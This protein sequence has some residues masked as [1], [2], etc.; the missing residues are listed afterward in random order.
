MRMLYKY[1]QAE[2]PYAA[3]VEENRRR[4]PNEPEFELLDTGVFDDDRYFDVEVDYAKAA[5]DDILMHIIVDQSRPRP[6]PLHVLPQLWA[7]N[8]WSWKPGPRNRRLR[9]RAA[10]RDRARRTR[11]CRRCGWSATARPRLLF[12]ENETNAAA[13]R[14]RRPAGYFKDGIN[15]YVVAATAA[16][17]NPAR[18]GTKAAAHYLR[19]IPAR[20]RR[21]RPAAAAPVRARPAAFDD[22]DAIIERRRDEADEFYAALQN[23]IADPDARARAASGARRHA[24]DEAV[25]LFRCPRWLHGDPAQPPPPP[26]AAR[27]Q[28]R[29]AAPQQRRHHLDAGQV[30]VSRGT[31]PGTW[32]FTASRLALIDPDFAKDQLLLLTREWYMHPNGQ[33]PAYEWAFGDV[34]PPVHAWAAWRVYQ[35]DRERTRHRRP[36]LSRSAFPQ[37]DAEFHLVGEPQGRRG[38]QRVPGRVS[39]ARQ[40]R[41]FRPQRAVADRRPHQPGRRHRLDGDVFAEPDAHR[42]GTGARTTTSTRTSRPSSSSTSSTSPQAMT[43]IGGDGIGLWDEED[44]FYYDVLH[45]PDGQ[46]RAAAGALDGRADP[47]VRGRGARRIACSSTC[48]NSPRRLRWFLDYRPDLAKLVSRWHE[49]AATSVT[50]CRC[51]AGIG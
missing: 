29:L 31:P 13:V 36:R 33:L 20:R 27:A 2:F 38:P 30:G 21:P 37:A 17:V 47:A 8:T 46:P 12:C 23:D 7:R 10:R 50:C 40:Y 42:P 5:P 44:E 48:P 45:L 3:L 51:C 11:A 32:P 43:N 39:R 9:A 18:V 25:L 1:P 22:F 34:N 35:I 49:P 28:R 16:A 41:H 4:G 19:P 14:G 26:S 6:A 24:V 15:D